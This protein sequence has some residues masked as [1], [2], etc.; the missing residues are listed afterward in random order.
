VS[1]HEARERLSARFPYSGF[2]P[3]VLDA[4]LEGGLT[5]GGSAVALRCHPEVEARAYEGA[6]ALDLAPVLSGVHI[7]ALVLQAEHGAIAPACLVRLAA[8]SP[9]LSIDR[10]PAATHFAALEQPAAVGRALAGFLAGL[11]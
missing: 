3:A 7:P 10:I 5:P 2:S 9:R 6:A 4:Y 8:G 11:P 1:R